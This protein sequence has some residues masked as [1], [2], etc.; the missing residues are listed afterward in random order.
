[1]TARYLPSTQLAIKNA[2]GEGRREE[3][4][5]QDEMN[6]AWEGEPAGFKRRWVCGAGGK[7]RPRLP[8]AGKDR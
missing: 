1:M 5:P 7:W 4:K 8:E 2:G 3:T 6:A